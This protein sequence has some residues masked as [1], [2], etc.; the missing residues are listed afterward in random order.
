MTNASKKRFLKSHIIAAIKMFIIPVT[1]LN[2]K[3]IYNIDNL[4]IGKY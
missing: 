1:R 4:Y 3:T 2:Q